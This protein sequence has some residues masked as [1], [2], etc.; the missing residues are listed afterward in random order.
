MENCFTSAFN[1]RF[2]TKTTQPAIGQY[3]QLAENV[4]LSDEHCVILLLWILPLYH[5]ECHT[6]QSLV[7]NVWFYSTFCLTRAHFLFFHSPTAQTRCSTR[8]R[9][10]QSVKRTLAFLLH[11]VIPT[12]RSGSHPR[13]LNHQRPRSV[14]RIHKQTRKKQY[15]LA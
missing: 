4:A 2:T 8:L 14:A 1:F 3:Q 13:S 5:R 10:R 15:N 11:N 6:K 9:R 12:F 7:I